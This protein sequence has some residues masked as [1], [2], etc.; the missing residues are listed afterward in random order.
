MKL[1]ALGGRYW[2]NNHS[3]SI[4]NNSMISINNNIITQ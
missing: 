1:A 2:V 4:S 3:I